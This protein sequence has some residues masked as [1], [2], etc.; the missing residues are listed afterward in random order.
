MGIRPRA[1]AAL[2]GVTLAASLTAAT[3]RHADQR[4]EDTAATAGANASRFLELTGDAGLSSGNATTEGETA[5]AEDGEIGSSPELD[6]VPRT[7]Q[8]WMLRPAGAQVDVLRFPL[9]LAATAD[10]SSIVVS[11]DGGGPQGLSIID[12]ATMTAVPTPAANLFMGVAITPAGRIYA[13]GGNADR[14]FQWQMAG[15]VAAPLDPTEAQPFPIHNGMSGRFP[16]LGLPGHLPVGDG[17]AVPGYPGHLVLDGDLL[18]VAGTLSEENDPANPCPGGQA[19]CARVSIIDITTGTIIGRAPVG[20]DAFGLAL[21]ADRG[22]LYVSNWAD[23][24]GRGDSTGGTVSVVDVSDP[25]T[26]SEI[27]VVGV[28]HHPSAL[29]LTADRTTLFVA[30]TNDDTISV[31]DVS[32]DGDPVVVATES[33]A[34]AAG[35]PVGAHPAAFALSPGGDT[36]FVALAG[37]NAIEVRDG[38]TGA[39]VAGEVHY[40]PTAW[41]PSALT[42]TGDADSYRLWVANAKGMGPGPGGNGSVLFQ[43]TQS[44]GTVSAIDL[45]VAP[46]QIEEWSEQVRENDQL[47]RVLVDACTP[48]QGIAVSEVLCPPDGQASPIRHVLYI[49]TENKTFDQYFGDINLTG[50]SGFDADPTWTLYGEAHTPNH[51]ALANRYSL[52]DRFFSDA[53]VS[54][55][56]HS[57]TSGAIATDYNERTWQADY[58]EGIR[59]NH[60]NGDPLREGVGGEAGGLIGQASDELGDPE[61]GYIFE[62]FRDAGAT[63]PSDNPGELSMAIY[64]EGTARESGD[65]SAYQAPAWKAGDLRY[66]DSCR[67]AQFIDGAAPNGPLPEGL[68]Q[69]PG[70]PLIGPATLNDCEGRTLPPQFSLAHW[71]QVYAETG[72]DVMPNFMYM[73]LPVNHTMGANLGSP[74]P[75]SMVADNDLAIGMIV[76]ALSNSP[77][78]ESTVVFVTEDDTQVAADHVSSLRDYLQVISPWASTGP[79]HQWG[80]MGSLLRTIET[81]FGIDPIAIYDGVALPQH[82][83]FVTSLDAEPNL[84]PYTAIRPIIPFAMNEPGLPGQELSEA[85]DFSTYDRIDEATLNAILYAIGRGTSY[86]EAQEF[87]RSLSAT[88]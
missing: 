22:L 63:P 32:G 87:L 64:G 80:S 29:Q 72:R 56:G 10:G 24:A 61:G 5:L 20:L 58:D 18:Y 69:S 43:G 19:A 39:R 30:N 81:I 40:I 77:F 27:G 33:V 50:G 84:A 88:G 52:G 21:D 53:E 74:T 60:G 12:A 70:I 62:A 49:V 76:E 83:A 44:G 71:E 47:D 8:G 68:P 15:P 66:F 45:P 41:Y 86:E 75:S 17:I 35:T 36:L 82:G 6:G 14:V 4:G 54:V 7:P 67:A 42:I 57:Y 48:A 25:A 34:P 65:M 28:G 38:R 78:W 1:L 23:E 3:A 51:H 2:V 31:L 11:S 9:G 46:E 16:D 26:A 37:M 59:G 13:S 73:S 55:T 85:M 79:N